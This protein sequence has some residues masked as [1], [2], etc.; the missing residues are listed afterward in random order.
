MIDPIE[1]LSQVEI[2]KAHIENL[3]DELIELWDIA[4]KTTS[5]IKEDAIFGSGNNDKMSGYVHEIMKQE[6]KL[7]AAIKEY[8]EKI[9][10]IYS[11]ISLLQ[12]PDYIK[13]LYK[14]YFKGLK[15]HEIGDEMF[16]SE[17][18]AQLT[19]AYALQALSV[20]LNGKN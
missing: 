14:K 2:Y 4:T 11:K 5:A 8:N 9:N 13:V 17:R 3:N 19:H 1:F 18:N 10:Y 15:W 6:E 12:S 16:M 7:K 20:I